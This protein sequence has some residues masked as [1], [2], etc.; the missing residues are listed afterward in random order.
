MYGESVAFTSSVDTDINQFAVDGDCF[1]DFIRV[2]NPK[3]E[4]YYAREVAQ[5][6][7]AK[8]E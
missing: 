3:L 5:G 6:I 2:G 4:W 1:P 7:G 8:E